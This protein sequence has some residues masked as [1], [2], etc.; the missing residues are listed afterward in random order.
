MYRLCKYA[1]K[2]KL[3]KNYKNKNRKLESEE[4]ESNWYLIRHTFRP[5]RNKT[6]VLLFNMH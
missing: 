3:Q 2:R 4:T 5:P 1:D 6:V